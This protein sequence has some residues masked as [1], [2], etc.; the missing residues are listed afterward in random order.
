MISK[1]ISKLSLLLLLKRS[2]N[3]VFHNYIILSFVF[4]SLSVKTVGKQTRT[5]ES[6]HEILSCRMEKYED[7]LMGNSVEPHQICQGVKA[8]T[9]IIPVKLP[10]HVK[11]GTIFSILLTMKCY[12]LC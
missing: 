6:A 8:A 11:T 4:V 1:N 2:T 12:H 3:S 5:G 10:L 7:M 9:L